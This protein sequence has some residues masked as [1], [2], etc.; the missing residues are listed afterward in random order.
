MKNLL[1]DSHILIWL[2]EDKKIGN[3]TRKNILTADN[4]YYSI[5]S[6]WELFIKS[7]LNKITLPENFIEKL[8]ESGLVKLSLDLEELK[9]YKI[10]EFDSFLKDP[11]DQILISQA[12]S[13]DL[14]LVTFDDLILKSYR[15]SIDGRG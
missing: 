14:Y 8:D 10:R 13:K 1:L 11:F 12:I 3:E 9:E 7:K 4:V 6:I 5:V 2:L 15:K